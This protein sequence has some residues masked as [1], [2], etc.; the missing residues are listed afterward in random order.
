MDSLTHFLVRFLLVPIITLIVVFI[1]NERIKT[2]KIGQHKKKLQ[3]L[4]DNRPLVLYLRSFYVDGLKEMKMDL[5]FGFTSPPF[6]INSF[7]MKLDR[8]INSFGKF[9]AIANPEKKET[10]LGAIRETFLN[11][12]WK[13]AVLNK[14][15]DAI[16]II[17][18]PSLSNGT[19]WEFVQLIKN[20]YLTKTIITIKDDYREYIEFVKVVEPILPNLPLEIYDET[21]ICI[22][23]QSNVSIYDDIRETPIF[24][25]F[26]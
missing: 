24:M 20:G 5:P 22:D 19:L 4:N 7:E 9:Y 12:E 11:D 21:F 17:F 13:A 16:I 25:R 2:K 15:K 23:N 14:M 3:F 8:H 10:E 6:P 1:L 18:R 26:T